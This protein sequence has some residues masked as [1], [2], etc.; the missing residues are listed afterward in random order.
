MQSLLVLAGAAA[1]VGLGVLGIRHAQRDATPGVPRRRFLVL[2][3]LGAAT[4]VGASRRVGLGGLFAAEGEEPTKLG[5]FA[6]LGAIWQTMTRHITGKLKD[7]EAFESLGKDMEKALA[8]LNALSEK[9][10]L[11]AESASA[12]GTAFR[13]R[14]AHVER[15]RYV[16][17]TCYSMS[18]LG[19]AMARSRGLMEQQVQT[20]DELAAGGKL[21]PEAEAK[22]R[23]VI[24]VQVAFL[25]QLRTLQ[26]QAAGEG[27]TAQSARQALGELEKQYTSGTITP[28]E[29]TR[30]AAGELVGFSVPARPKVTCYLIM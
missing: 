20:L 27:E 15:T 28:S 17:A 6:W 11:S 3:A 5:V 10:E 14:Y 16:M 19:G 26:E 8:D 13:E 7:R 12:V 4:L 2:A 21:T 24:A 9:G 22:A 23:S 29:A 18:S 30:Q 25:S 1:V